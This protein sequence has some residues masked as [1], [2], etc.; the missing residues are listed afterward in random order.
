M[1]ERGILFSAPM[2][3][4]LIDG[5][6]T[7]TR[8]EVKSADLERAGVAP[9]AQAILIDW[10]ANRWQYCDN[11]GYH[12]ISPIRCRYGAPGDLLWVRESFWSCKDTKRFLWYVSPGLINVDRKRD[13]ARLTPGI[14]M[15]R[16]L[17]RITREVKNIR[18]ERLFDIS[19]ADCRAEGML[20]VPNGWTTDEGQPVSETAR[21]AYEDLW[22]SIN[23]AWLDC[24]VWVIE[25]RRVG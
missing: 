2:V 7:Q 16:H 21:R 8:R 10:A 12:D 13:N 23:G 25:F 22:Y 18:I 20:Q 14:H 4:A 15:P 9:H 6:K 24:W 11:D 3:Q 17:A 1:K 5:R 19:E